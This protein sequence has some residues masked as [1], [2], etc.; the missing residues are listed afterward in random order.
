MTGT[1]RRLGFAPWV[2]QGLHNGNGKTLSGDDAK[3]IHS[4]YGWIGKN[5]SESPYAILDHK[6]V[7][8]YGDSTTRQVWASY[9]AP[10]QGNH[11][12]RN[13]KEWTRQYV[14]KRCDCL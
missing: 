8:M 5:V 6:W 3:A 7:Y 11:F 2:A 1:H 9:A 10:F 13:A 4:K 14:S 12:E